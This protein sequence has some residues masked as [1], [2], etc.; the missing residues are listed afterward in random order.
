MT[1]KQLGGGSWKVM[2]DCCTSGNCVACRHL[3]FGRKVRIVHGGGF[4]E[5]H[6][7]R[8]AVNWATYNAKAVM[9]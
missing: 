7:K 9:S 3:P 5:A 1:G 4:T 6:A 2:R 8:V